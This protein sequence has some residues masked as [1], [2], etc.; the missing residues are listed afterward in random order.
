M[1]RENVSERILGIAEDERLVRLLAD[2]SIRALPWP[3]EFSSCS[4]C[5]SWSIQKH[6]IANTVLRSSCAPVITGF[7]VLLCRL[8]AFGSYPVGNHEAFL[9]CPSIFSHIHGLGWDKRG[10]DV[11]R[12]SQLVAKLEQGRGK[13][14]RVM[15][16]G[17]VCQEA[18]G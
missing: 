4:A 14:G 1:D 12:Q 10:V 18:F 8:D 16:G 13:S 11:S 3:V 2:D 5:W 15:D 7:L 17:P 6:E 9:E